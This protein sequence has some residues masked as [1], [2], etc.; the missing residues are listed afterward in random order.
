MPEPPRRE[1]GYRLYLEADITRIRFIRCAKDLGFSLKEISEVLSLGID[2]DTPCGEI[3]KRA[4]AK[5]VDIEDRIRTL[6]DMKRALA[7]T[8]KVMPGMRPYQ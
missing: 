5:I 6:Y 8:C 7:K 3:K 2:P 1:S 4:E